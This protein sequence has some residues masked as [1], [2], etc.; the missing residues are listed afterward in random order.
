MIAAGIAV[1]IGL[2]GAPT[3]VTYANPPGDV[4][5]VSL[6]AWADSRVPASIAA[7]VTRVGSDL[8]VATDPGR[9][10]VLRFEREDGSYMIDGPFWWPAEDMARVL[11]RRWR[12]TV[13]ASTADGIQ[14]D[15]QFEWVSAAAGGR[16][17]WPRCFAA[18]ERLWS[19][20]GV[21]R[22]EDGVLAGRV[23]DR[24]WSAVV[25]EGAGPGSSSSL[26]PTTP[27]VCASVSPDP[28]RPPRPASP[29]SVWKRRS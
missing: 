3:R 28:P 7:D 27:A 1:L 25:G 4:V 22:D 8:I 18:G 12:R 9:R 23:G 11:E 19:C 6:Y 13:A 16:G 10:V 26:A 14:A 20:W 2:G 17:E 24:I 5:R 15:A 21:L 29:A